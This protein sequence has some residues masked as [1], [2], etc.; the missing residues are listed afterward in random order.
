MF[1]FTLVSYMISIL[2]S[3]KNQE[4]FYWK[5]WLKQCRKTEELLRSVFDNKKFMSPNE[6]ERHA[7]R[8]DKCFYDGWFA[9]VQSRFTRATATALKNNFRW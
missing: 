8:C 1:L 6:I 5:C 7:E 2:L 9:S 3:K 4:N